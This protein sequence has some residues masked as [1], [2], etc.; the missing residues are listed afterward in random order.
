MV[1]ISGSI[2]SGPGQGGVNGHTG[3]T[4]SPR[5][6]VNINGDVLFFNFTANAA[7]NAIAFQSSDILT[8]TGSIYQG[9][10]GPSTINSTTANSSIYVSGSIISR[11]GTDS[12][13]NKTSTGGVVEIIG[14]IYASRSTP[15]IQN[16]S[17][18][19]LTRISG[20]IYSIENISIVP[21]YS[22]TIQLFSNSTIAYALP[23]DTF[24]QT[25]TFYDV[26]YTSSLPAQTDVRSGSLYGGTNEYSG[27][28]VVPSTSSVRYGVPVDNVTG[29]ATLTPQD[30]LT[31]AVQN[32]TGSNSI[33]AR[34]QNI[35]TV[36]TTAAT[37]AAFKGK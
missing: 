36:Q 14:P 8:I 20:P 2:E 29:S 5:G 9:D 17:T 15:I 19:T 10:F 33:G 18:S 16:T 30:I 12:A 34:L 6:S 21:V 4:V 11:F 22:P 1:N 7:N 37:I 32:L 31:Y 24:N 26:S 23:S 28:M 13:I 25:V 3:I 35:A 27:S